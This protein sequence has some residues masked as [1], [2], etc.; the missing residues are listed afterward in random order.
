MMQ[1]Q[2]PGLYNAKV[3]RLHVHMFTCFNIFTYRC[4]DEEYVIGLHIFHPGRVYFLLCFF[5]V[6]TFRQKYYSRI[7][8]GCAHVLHGHSRMP[9]DLRIPLMPGRSVLGGPGR[10]SLSDEGDTFKRILCI[11]T[12]EVRARRDQGTRGQ[13]PP[14][15]ADKYNIFRSFFCFL[16]LHV[17][18]DS[19][20][21]ETWLY[22]APISRLWWV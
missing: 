3:A 18:L 8:E 17:H 20:C 1:I 11:A 6:L 12:A 21:N 14:P 9:I 13:R 5:F 16:L 10:L 7:S 22:I 4:D 15:E 2:C 19:R